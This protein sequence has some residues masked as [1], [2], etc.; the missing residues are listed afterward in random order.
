MSE[1]NVCPLCGHRVRERKYRKMRRLIDDS[2][3]PNLVRAFG[4]EIG[5]VDDGLDKTAVQQ[6]NHKRKRRKS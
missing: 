1:K 3:L 4:Y 5:G 2:E 6:G